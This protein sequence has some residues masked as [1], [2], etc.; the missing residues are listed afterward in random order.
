MS[1]PWRD[2]VATILVAIGLFVYGAWAI[3]AALP[4]FGDV[5]AV[6]LAVLVLGIAASASAVV[7]GFAELLRGSR[8]YLVVASG[9]GVV[10]LVGGLWAVL[11]GESA[12]LVVLV[13]ATIAMWAMSTARHVGAQRPTQRLGTR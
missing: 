3:G 11:E 1:I 12:G 7:P 8:A 9:L 6:A 13:L 5:G 10:A 4:A 2:V